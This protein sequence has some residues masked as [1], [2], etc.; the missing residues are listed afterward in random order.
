[1]K[2][3][4][5]LLLSFILVFSTIQVVFADTNGSMSNFKETKTYTDGQF[6]DVSTNDWFAENVKKAYE[7]GLISGTSET[8]FSPDLELTFAEIVALSCR[9]HSIYNGNNYEFKNSTPWYQTYFDYN[10]ENRLI[11]FEL[12]YNSKVTRGQFAWIL[13]ST[14]PL[15]E[16]EPINNIAIG[17]I[18]DADKYDFAV[19]PLYNAG[20]LSG[21][22]EYGTFN[23]SSTIKRSEVAAIITRVVDKSLRKE[24]KLTSTLDKLQGT[25]HS[26]KQSFWNYEENKFDE[27]RTEIVIDG[28]QFSEYYVSDG[29]FGASIYKKGII[30]FAENGNCIN[31]SSRKYIQYIDGGCSV[32]DIDESFNIVEISDNKLTLEKVNSGYTY[33]YNKGEING[34]KEKCLSE[35]NEL[36]TLTPNDFYVDKNHYPMLRTLTSVTGAQCTSSATV[37]SNDKKEGYVPGYS[38]YIYEFPMPAKTNIEAY[39]NHFKPYIEYLDNELGLEKLKVSG[40]ELVAPFKDISHIYILNN[41][42]N[43]RLSVSWNLDDISE[44]VYIMIMFL[45]D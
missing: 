44:K 7:L 19:Y 26:V 10:T 21:S 41:A 6:S 13:Y 5:S 45:H 23:Q 31:I 38:V 9:I 39:E 12:E 20:I 2:K 35:V 25:W 16:F 4:I 29:D 3:I 27:I 30:S 14:L 17:T 33:T 8:T 32:T 42:Q 1:M 11:S 22:D 18:P 24:F 37:L 43:N 40:S 36:L 15:E 34:H 28:N